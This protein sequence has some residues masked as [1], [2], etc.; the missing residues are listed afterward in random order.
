M[1]VGRMM[2]YIGNEYSFISHSK[3]TKI[4]VLADVL[5]ILTQAM[6]ASMLVREAPHLI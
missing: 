4:F 6:G 2:S 3:I 1:I 5:A